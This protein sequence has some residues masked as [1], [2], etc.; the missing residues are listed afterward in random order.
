MRGVQ[1]VVLQGEPCHVETYEILTCVSL[2]NQDDIYIELNSLQTQQNYYI[3]IDGY[4]HDYCGFEI[5]V[6][7]YAKG[8]SVSA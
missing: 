3:N 6:S 7:Q 5:E 1:I 2:A 8:L 4:L